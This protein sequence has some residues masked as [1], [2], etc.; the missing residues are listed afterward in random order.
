MTLIDLFREFSAVATLENYSGSSRILYYTLLYVWNER[1]R[2]SEVAVPYKQ[3]C[4]LTGLNDATFSKA[5]Q[6]LSSRHWIKKFK[7]RNRSI[8]IYQMIYQGNEKETGLKR[9]SDFP[10]DTR[11][12]EEKQTDSGKGNFLQENFLSTT[13]EVDGHVQTNSTGTK[14]S[15][16]QD[17]FTEVESALRQLLNMGSNACG[18]KV[19]PLQKLR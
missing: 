18:K 14:D 4:A 8:L 13:K 2:P 7:S 16:N 11:T 15:P 10:L 3:L 12:T 5:I 6:Y 19:I 17:V 1:R 9:T